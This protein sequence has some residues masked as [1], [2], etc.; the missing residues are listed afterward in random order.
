MIITAGDNVTK[1]KKCIEKNCEGKDVIIC[2]VR[3]E[4]TNIVDFESFIK[5]RNHE[6]IIDYNKEQ[7][8]DEELINTIEGILKKL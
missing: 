4:K 5:E 7:K 1:L 8:K 2:A 6:K 3:D